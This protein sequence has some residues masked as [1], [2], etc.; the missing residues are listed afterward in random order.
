MI[1]VE[2]SFGQQSIPHLSLPEVLLCVLDLQVLLRQF[3]IERL[4]D[5]HRFELFLNFD[6]YY[7]QS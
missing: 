4:L 1:V 5:L 2:L 6:I 7:V 3:L